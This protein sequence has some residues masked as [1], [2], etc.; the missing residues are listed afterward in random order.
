MWILPDDTAAS[1][2]LSPLS[3]DAN[4]YMLVGVNETSSVYATCSKP[5]VY[6]F[7]VYGNGND[8][9][10]DTFYVTVMDGT[11]FQWYFALISDSNSSPV[12]RKLNLGVNASARIW[13]I[14]YSLASKGEMEGISVV[15]STQSKQLSR[16]LFEMGE[17]PSVS[18]LDKNQF[19]LPHSHKASFDASLG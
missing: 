4:R 18:I 11:N 14:D 6:A 9:L 2:S 15:P 12:A 8:S 5:G 17:N 1:C 13:I 19:R 7:K 10:T 16:G 3:N